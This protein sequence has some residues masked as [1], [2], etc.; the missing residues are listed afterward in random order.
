MKLYGLINLYAAAALIA[1]FFHS[2]SGPHR[3]DGHAARV[4]LGAKVYADVQDS[5]L[6]WSVLGRSVSHRQVYMLELGEGDSTAIIFGGF[7]GS[8]ISSVQLVHRFAELLYADT[9]LE[10][11]SK[12]III[13][14]LN[15]DGLVQARRRNENG[16]DINRNFPT[17]NWVASKGSKRS[18]HGVVPAS[19]PET[20]IAIDLLERYQP[21]RIITVHA[22][23][24][25]VNYDGPAKSLAE[26]MATFNHYPVKS[27]IGYATPGSFGTYA[28]K[29]RQIPTITLE[30]PR[31][32]FTE[33]VW[34]VNSNALLAAIQN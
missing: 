30:L 7:H 27:D 24:E 31:G 34:E 3:S 11:N 28:G 9:S 2:C 5:Q 13:P 29:E 12:V 1:V 16:I 14:V 32:S 8:E 17:K 18:S 23:L 10:L 19:E 25:V 33:E 4:K 15:P 21:D 20:I 6:P 22:P 26:K